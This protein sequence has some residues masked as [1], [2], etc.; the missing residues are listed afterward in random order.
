MAAMARGGRFPAG[1]GA[2]SPTAPFTGITPGFGTGGSGG[3]GSGAPGTPSGGAI[4]VSG[5]NTGTNV[6]HCSFDNNTAYGTVS[7]FAT[8]PGEG[9][10]IYCLLF[11]APN[12]TE[13]TFT[14]NHADYA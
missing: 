4:Y 8:Y 13:C 9:G 14:N 7:G 3:G 10:A 6:V 1:F 11:T 5:I 2:P 12:V